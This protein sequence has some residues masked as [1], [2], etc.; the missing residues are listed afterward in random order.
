MPGCS[1]RW[2]SRVNGQDDGVLD[3]NTNWHYRADGSTD[4]ILQSICTPVTMFIVKAGHTY[5]GVLIRGIFRGNKR[6][7]VKKLKPFDEPTDGAWT[8][9]GPIRKGDGGRKPAKKAGRKSAKATAKSRKPKTAPA[10]K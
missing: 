9:Q 3:L 2:H 5:D 1:G 8:A 7:R 6:L 4:R 10:K